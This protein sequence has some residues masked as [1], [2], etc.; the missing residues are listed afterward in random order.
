MVRP[1][2]EERLPGCSIAFKVLILILCGLVAPYPWVPYD[3]S[4]DLY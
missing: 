3:T 1:S 4:E 2:E